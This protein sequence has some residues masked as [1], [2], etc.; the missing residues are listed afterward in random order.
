MCMT[1]I[2]GVKEDTFVVSLEGQGAQGGTTL[3]KDG[4]P[5][6]LK[7]AELLLQLLLTR[8]IWASDQDRVRA[9]GRDRI[10]K[11]SDRDR[12]CDDCHPDTTNMVSSSKF[13]LRSENLF[14]TCC[15]AQLHNG[16]ARRGFD[17]VK[18][19]NKRGVD[20]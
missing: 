14:H 4:M 2:L 1:V 11:Y 7:V 13:C 20:A 9:T 18:G 16:K 15:V 5:G 8:D 17:N 12:V 19:T 6:L 10:C 3:G